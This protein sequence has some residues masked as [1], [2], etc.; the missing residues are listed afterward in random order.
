MLLLLSSLSHAAYV[1]DVGDAVNLG[2][3][4]TW[5]RAFP[6]DDGNWWMFIGAGGG[7]IATFDDDLNLVTD[8][9]P[10]TGVQNMQDH[11]V[12]R[13][14]DGGFLHV[15]SYT[16][17]NHNDSARTW[18]YDATWNVVSEGILEEG[19]QNQQHNDM[20]IVCAD[21]WK[22]AAFR[23][24]GQP[25]SNGNWYAI[26]RDST[27]GGPQFLSGTPNITGS[28]L[29]EVDGDL[30]IW[31]VPGFQGQGVVRA[32]YD[33]SYNS[34]GT[35]NEARLGPDSVWWTQ[36][37]LKAGDVTLIAFMGKD[38]GQNFNG[39]TGDVYLAVLDADMK[40]LETRQITDINDPSGAMRPGIS[41]RGETLMITWDH[42]VESYASK[43]TL[44]L[45]GAGSFDSGE[46]ETGDPTG[47]DNGG[48]NG[49]DDTGGSG[50]DG[51]GGGVA[52]AS[53]CA[54]GGGAA[55]IWLFALGLAALRRRRQG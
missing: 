38:N 10:L 14:P 32:V 21:N 54:S 15:A 29:Q 25:G 1:V 8:F 45:S 17:N 20:G 30:A 9:E 48:D 24:E 31:G 5:V 28:A 16:T 11:G 4:A 39:D 19:I 49:T 46:F 50:D 43:I 33:S 23:A 51:G 36:G 44:D 3:N 53:G 2:R 6:K 34:A 55:G 52:C 26:D 37:V 40:V 42:N 18:R 41:R 22:G 27:H 7:Q 12:V 13:C 47:S 35:S